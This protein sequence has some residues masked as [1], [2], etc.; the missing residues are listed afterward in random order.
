MILC[1]P[2][3]IPQTVFQFQSDLASSRKDQDVMIGN[4]F[5]S[6]LVL[7]KAGVGVVIIPDNSLIRDPDLVYIPVKGFPA[8]SFGVYY[9]TL[10]GNAA[11]KAFI[12]II[13]AKLA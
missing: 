6:S 3:S 4:G 2:H 10:K 1:E 11:L 5:E 8:I 12:E 9:K 7:T 13:K